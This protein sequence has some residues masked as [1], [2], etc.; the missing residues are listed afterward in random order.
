MSA[1]PPPCSLSHCHGMH[2]RLPVNRPLHPCP[3][4]QA[5]E[6]PPSWR[7]SCGSRPSPPAP[8]PSSAPTWPRRRCLRC[9]ASLRSSRRRRCSSPARCATTWTR[10]APTKATTPSWR[11]PWRWAGSQGDGAATAPASPQAAPPNA[12]HFQPPASWPHPHAAPPPTP[13]P[14]GGANVGAAVPHGAV[15]RRHR[16]GGLPRVPPR[17]RPDGAD[18]QQARRARRAPA[19]AGRQQRR[20]RR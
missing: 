16:H 13:T 12:R 11:W 1:P 20:K 10:S 6:S 5:L 8:S 2:V 19:L 17:G 18:A 4:Q 9:G 3:L 15:P 14:P 7:P